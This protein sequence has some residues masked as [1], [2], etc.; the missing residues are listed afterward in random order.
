[1][2]RVFASLGLCGLAVGQNADPI[3]AAQSM[4]IGQAGKV[5]GVMAQKAEQTLEQKMST[6]T[7]ECTDDHCCPGSS[8]AGFMLPCHASRGST[9]CVGSNAL[10]LHEGVCR[11]VTGPCNEG[12]F[13]PD[14]P[15]I[16]GKSPGG[17]TPAGAAPGTVASTAAAAAPGAAPSASA[18]Q[19]AAAAPPTEVS[20][21][22]SR[23]YARGD[24]SESPDSAGFLAMSIGGP[25]VGLAVG[26]A[27]LVGIVRLFRRRN[28]EFHEDDGEL[29]ETP[30]VSDAVE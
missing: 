12:G 19:P 24:L 7:Q 23:L 22:W 9:T 17:G 2:R 30:L 28:T 14:A 10:Q 20:T 6:P 27:V 13:C 29:N 16:A 11:C 3:A 1:M 5:A 18:A 21:P 15:P 8:C 25:F 4:M 26:A